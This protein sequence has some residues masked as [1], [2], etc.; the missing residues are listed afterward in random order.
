MLRKRGTWQG[1]QQKGISIFTGNV[2]VTKGQDELKAAKVT[3]Y[4][5]QDKKPIKYIAEGNVKFKIITEL[6]EHYE[7][8]SQIAIF[9]PN[10]NEYHFFKKVD[11]IRTDDYRRVKGDKVVVNTVL[12]NATADSA[13]N[14]PVIMIFN[15]QEQA[16][17]KPSTT[18][19]SESKW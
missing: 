12:G 14:E 19:K 9:Y 2:F 4:T 7:G 18:T 15:M 11:L 13:K 8:E 3:I 17:N 10:D 1:D 6:K 16:K 5:D